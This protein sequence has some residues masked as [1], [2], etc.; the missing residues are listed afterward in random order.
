MEKQVFLQE[1]PSR[2]GEDYARILRESLEA[3]AKQLE[4]DLS[5]A[6]RENSYITDPTAIVLRSAASELDRCN[7]S[8]RISNDSID[9]LAWF[10][11]GDA[12][13]IRQLQQA[14]NDLH[15]TNR[16]SEDGVYGKKSAAATITFLERLDRSVVP[17]LKWV[18]PLQSKTSGIT[19]GPSEGS[20]TNNSFVYKKHPYIRVDKPHDGTGWVNGIKVSSNQYHLNFD[21]MPNS[22][23]LYDRYRKVL[24]HHPL[25]AKDYERIRDLSK[26]GRTFR[27]GGQK[28]LIAGKALVALELVFAVFEDVK[29]AD[30][31]LDNL[32]SSAVSITSGWALSAIGTKVGA[33]LSLL[34][35]PAAPFAAPPLM[36]IGG[37]FGSFAS[38][39]IEDDLT[40]WVLDITDLED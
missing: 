33:L 3:I 30:G 34:A 17:A 8:P 31:K 36:L 21:S 14:L 29:D 40:A 26:V 32:V 13:K 24:S 6:E 12:E 18:D 22:T 20:S 2:S 11:G 7:I 16:L 10:V 37:F 38:T 9:R 4:R 19:L 5:I 28:L 15:I 35:G 1:L 39:L 27:K 25:S 23:P